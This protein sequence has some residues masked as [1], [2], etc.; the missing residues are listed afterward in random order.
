VWMLPLLILLLA[1][2][3]AGV[4]LA[5]PGGR[6]PTTRV[7]AER[8]SLTA[9]RLA[10]AY[11]ALRSILSLLFTHSTLALVFQPSPALHKKSG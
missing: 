10:P 9:F 7:Q 5:L 11:M 4:A 8:R 1:M 3:L 2:A 6:P